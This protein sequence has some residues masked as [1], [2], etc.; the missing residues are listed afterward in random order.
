MQGYVTPAIAARYAKNTAKF[1]YSASF[2]GKKTAPAAE[3][4]TE[5][6]IIAKPDEIPEKT[7]I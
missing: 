2:A 5:H 7:G 6:I 4:A 3:A 1:I